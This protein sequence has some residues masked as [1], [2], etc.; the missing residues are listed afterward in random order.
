MSEQLNYRGKIVTSQDITFLR[1]FIADNQEL[2]RWSLSRK[3]CEVWGWKQ[4]NG[5]LRDMVCRGLLLMLDR[6]GQIELP[7]ARPM[8]QRRVGASL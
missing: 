4:A 1:R 5:S 6:A 7:A 3:L 8:P 2:S